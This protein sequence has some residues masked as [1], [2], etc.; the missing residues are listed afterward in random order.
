MNAT[1]AIFVGALNGSALGGGAELAWACDLRL[2]AAGD[3]FIG[4]PEILLGFNPGGGGTQRLTRLIGTHRSLKAMLEGRPFPAQEALEL[5]LIDELVPP[6]RLVARS[7]EVA[8]GLARRP[9][10]G[11][12]AVKRSVYLGASESLVAGLQRERAE[13]VSVLGSDDAQ[14]RMLEYMARTDADGELPLYDPELYA[15]AL[16]TGRVAGP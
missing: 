1:G 14:A 6:D 16:E 11:I 4:Q 2:M 7:V 3:H 5:G 13:F 9:K 8:Q 15:E 10:D 12:A